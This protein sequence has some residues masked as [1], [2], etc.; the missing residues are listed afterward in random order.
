MGVLIYLDAFAG[1]NKSI[2]LVYQFLSVHKRKCEVSSRIDKAVEGQR[3]A[4][5]YV[6]TNSEARMIPG[7]LLVH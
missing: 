6:F 7:K 3:K 2:L 5:L 1:V 4:S